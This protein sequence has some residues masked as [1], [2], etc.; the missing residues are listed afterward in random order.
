MIGA[1]RCVICGRAI[2]K[3]CTRVHGGAIG[4]TCARKIGISTRKARLRRA[5][6]RHEATPVDPRQVDWVE[7]VA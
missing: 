6:I 1:I 3:V 2:F 7:A 5:A 4:P